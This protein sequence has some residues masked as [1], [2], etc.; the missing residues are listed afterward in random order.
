MLV[1][2]AT[3]M[4]YGALYHETHEMGDQHSTTNLPADL[5]AMLRYQSVIVP[6]GRSNARTH[7][8]LP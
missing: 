6:A 2:L 4:L 7:R 1:A 5:A 3:A 8:S